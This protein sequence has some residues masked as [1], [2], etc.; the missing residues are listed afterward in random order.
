MVLYVLTVYF[1]RGWGKGCGEKDH[2]GGW[3]TK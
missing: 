2:Q 3:D 1:V